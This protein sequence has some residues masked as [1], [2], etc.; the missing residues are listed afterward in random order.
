M[1][2][3]TGV[4]ARARGGSGVRLVKVE[5]LRAPCRSFRAR[6]AL[7]ELLCPPMPTMNR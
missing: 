5:L 4:A 1:A 6:H 3:Y 2:P 7:T